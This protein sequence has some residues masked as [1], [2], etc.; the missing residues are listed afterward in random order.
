MNHLNI[1][2]E[3]EAIASELQE[4]TKFLGAYIKAQQPKTKKHQQAAKNKKKCKVK[5]KIPKNKI[6]KKKKC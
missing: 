6:S 4:C 1:T 2:E 5:K 3:L